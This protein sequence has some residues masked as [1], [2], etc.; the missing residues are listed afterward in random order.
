[1]MVIRSRTLNGLPH[2]R[3]VSHTSLTERAMSGAL[4]SG[5]V[6]AL[7]GL[8]EHLTATHTRYPGTNLTLHSLRTKAAQEAAQPCIHEP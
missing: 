3:G 7:A 8:C 1:M 5:A 6:N 4:M 2:N